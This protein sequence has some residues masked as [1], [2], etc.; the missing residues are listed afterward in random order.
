[1]C[2]PRLCTELWPHI[3]SIRSVSESPELQYYPWDVTLFSAVSLTNCSEV[4]HHRFYKL[5]Q[6]QQQGGMSLN[7]GLPS[8]EWEERQYLTLCWVVQAQEEV[9]LQTCDAPSCY[10]CNFQLIAK[11][12]TRRHLAFRVK[13][14]FQTPATILSRKPTARWMLI[15]CG[16]ATAFKSSTGSHRKIPVSDVQQNILDFSEIKK[17][18]HSSQI[19][20]FFIIMG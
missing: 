11:P 18:W 20:S 9:C 13:S 14:A 10:T 19:Q 1:M 12:F 16:W 4:S 17:Q 5:V 6:P 7:F 3:S 8:P 15:S 2:W